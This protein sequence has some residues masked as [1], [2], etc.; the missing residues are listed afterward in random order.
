MVLH[1]AAPRSAAQA[2]ALDGSSV[3]DG[4]HGQPAGLELSSVSDNGTRRVALIASPVAKLSG[5]G[6]PLFP[7]SATEHQVI[8]ARWTWKNHAGDGALDRRWGRF[9]VPARDDGTVDLT[10][11]T[12]LLVV[13]RRAG[14][15][16]KVPPIS[17][18]LRDEAE[19]ESKP[20]SMLE[21]NLVPL[22]D[23]SVTFAI[24]IASITNKVDA[25]KVASVVF[26]AGGEVTADRPTG[27]YIDRVALSNEKSMPGLGRVGSAY[28]GDKV[29]VT[30]DARNAP[31]SVR[32]IADGQWVAEA[33]AG[34]RQLVVES[35][36]LEGAKSI[37]LVAV[38]A[39]IEG[40]LVPL[41][42]APKREVKSAKLT[43]DGPARATPIS[44]WLL[45]TN[46]QQ[47]ETA[48][49]Q[50]VSVVRWGGNHTS[51][52]NWK[53]DTTNSANDWYHMT[54]THGEKPW[55]K[56]EDSRWYKYIKRVRDDGMDVSLHIP[57]SDWVSRRPKEGEPS[58]SFPKS[59]YPEQQ[60]FTAN[61]L[62]GNGRTPDGKY[63]RMIDKSLTFRP[64]TVEFQRE[65]IKTIIATFG[66]ADQGGVR[67]Y[68]LDNEVNL[69]HSSHFG[70]NPEGIDG[71]ELVWRNIAY[72]KML[73]EEDPSAMVLG[74]SGWGQ[75]GVAGSDRDYR[76]GRWSFLPKELS[77]L[78]RNELRGGQ[79]LLSWY[80]DEM[81]Q[82]EVRH[83]HR[84]IDVVAI[85]WYP[86][87][88]YVDPA[89]G[90]TKSLTDEKGPTDQGYDPFVTPLQFD[91]L[92]YWWD[93]TY[94]NE[95]S[96]TFQ[97]ANRAKFW[98]PYT[99]VLPKLNAIIE[100]HYPGT[101]LAITEYMLGSEETM[102]GA[103]LQ[104]MSIGIFAE[105]DLFSA[106]RWFGTRASTWAYW[107]YALVGNWDGQ[108]GGIDGCY[109]KVVSDV[110][111][112]SA[113]STV[114]ANT[115]RQHVVVV[116]QNYDQPYTVT[117]PAEGAR[118][119]RLSV[120]N[121]ATGKQVVRLPAEPIT[122]ETAT[123]VVPAFSAVMC[124][125]EK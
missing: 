24:P 20:V 28:F 38:A 92:R 110:K 89:T 66:R 50:G 79:D 58:G 95:A 75:M 123:F 109:R 31:R 55:E 74:F 114:N 39:D 33:P 94:V 63:I 2:R 30:W 3:E 100:K 106:Q 48:A 73:K 68:G 105:N 87:L 107:G 5:I 36:R 51:T 70:A 41:V 65:W 49:G 4:G 96:W 97:G 15:D 13:A 101:K 84:L 71:P 16:T 124:V 60:K 85:N 91:S 111:E 113:W 90:K 43:Y 35:S 45:G 18:G 69:W 108:R 21:Y 59:L 116:N 102:T 117:L 64:N 61:G 62:Y 83:G 23:A 121:E 78:E 103:L 25:A 52:Y 47:I 22:G 32:L 26:E 125:L 42:L 82:A 86:F 56:V 118:S 80:L 98:D 37:A 122:G 120:L 88:G 44:K 12:Y 54:G 6:D 8:D 40:P 27:W 99:P 76:R 14:D 17:I 34:D 10:R 93:P 57:I 72:A 7:T 29:V 67:F 1:L 46:G 53:D 9:V 104:V 19:A 11:Q 119:L 115:G 81:R 77:D 112:L